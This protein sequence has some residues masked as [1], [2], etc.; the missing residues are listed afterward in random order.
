[1][2]EENKVKNICFIYSDIT[3]TGGIEKSISVIANELCKINEY[4]ISKVLIKLFLT[5][6]KE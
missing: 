2:R 1:M 6:M 3:T 4:N 5:L